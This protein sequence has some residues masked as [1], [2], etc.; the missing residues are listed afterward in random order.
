MRIIFFGTPE[1]AIPSLE[2]IVDS[3]YELLTVVTNPD[4]KS[5]RGLKALPTPVKSFSKEKSIPYISYNDFNEDSTYNDL[6]NMAPDLFVVVAFKVLPER[7]INIPKYGSI[8]LH[9]SLLPKYRGSSPIQHAILNGDKKTGITIFKLNQKVDSGEVI[10]QEDYPINEDIVFSEL[11]IRLSERGSKLL[12]K[13]IELIDSGKAEY[14]SQN[15][16]KNSIISKEISYAKKITP[17]DCLIDWSLSAKTINNKIRAF[18]KTPGAF[19]YFKDKKVKILNSNIYK[20]DLLTLNQAQVIA[21]QKK[22]LVGTQDFPIQVN[23][24][25]VEGKKEIKGSDFINS[26]LFMNDKIASFG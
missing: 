9:P 7:I 18:S 2:S 5:G 22:L 1:F 3:K 8:N 21:Y 23:F 25:Q 4:K 15:P 19:T 6:K 20:N 12:L 24:L 26:N 17:K 13:S 14:I 11:Y 10:L 16:C